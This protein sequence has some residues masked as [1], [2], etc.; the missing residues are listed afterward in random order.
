[1]RNGHEWRLALEYFL[2]SSVEPGNKPGQLAN[3]EINP[4]VDAVMLRFNYDFDW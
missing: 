1:M 3:Q 4:D 2:Q